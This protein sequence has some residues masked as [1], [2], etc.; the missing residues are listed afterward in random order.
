MTKDLSK[1][2]ET[3]TNRL[4]DKHHS[5][6]L[7]IDI[8]R[9]TWDACLTALAAQSGE[10][11]EKAAIEKIIAVN[12]KFWWHSMFN[13]QQLGVLHV[14]KEQFEQ[15]KATK[16]ALRL[17]LRDI[18]E[19]RDIAFQIQ[20]EHKRRIAE[21]EAALKQSIKFLSL[22]TPEYEPGYPDFLAYLRALANEKM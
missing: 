18:T 4:A 5:G 15:D 3:E 6:S 9:E 19:A 12:G 22:S 8:V 1:L 10:F 16:A 2:R 14:L 7:V 11:D 17:E 13:D 20:I 21:L